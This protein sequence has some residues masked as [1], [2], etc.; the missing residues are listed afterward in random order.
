V[1]LVRAREW[2]RKQRRARGDGHHV[3]PHSLIRALQ[4]RHVAAGAGAVERKVEPP[5]AAS[6]C[7]HGRGAGG[8]VAHVRRHERDARAVGFQ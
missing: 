8:F 3:V 4:R 7:V 6:H 1:A 2:R 5:E